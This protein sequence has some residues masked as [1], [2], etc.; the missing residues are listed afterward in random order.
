MDNGREGNGLLYHFWLN[1]LEGAAV[2]F[3]SRR[4]AAKKYEIKE[5][6]DNI[7]NVQFIETVMQSSCA[8]THFIFDEC[9]IYSKF[10][11]KGGKGR[12]F[13]Y[14][15]SQLKKSESLTISATVCIQPILYNK[16][17][18]NLKNGKIQVIPPIS[19]HHIQLTR[20]YR[21]SKT[22]AKVTREIMTHN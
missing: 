16:R 12:L 18:E 4:E 22:V 6:Q 20:Q 21:S 17:D 7:D 10:S 13:S 2:A 19:S 5:A 1:I 14:D 8:D 11:I 3:M 9:P 15:W